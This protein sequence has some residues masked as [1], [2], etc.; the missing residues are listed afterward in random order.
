MKIMTHPSTT[1]TSHQPSLNL[2]PAPV[3][4]WQA[5]AFWL[6]LGFI[7]FGGPAG[8]IAMMHKELVEERRWISE[9]RF[10]HALNYCMLLPGPEAQQLATYIG[11][12][13]HRTWGGIAAGVLFVLPSLLILMGLSWIYI[14]YGSLPLV[15][16]LF[17]GI[18][19]AVTAIVL[20]A[21][22]R[23]G[24]RALKNNWLWGIAGASFVAIF[25][26]NVPFPLIVVVAAMVGYF[27]GRLYPNVFKVGGGHGAAKATY[28]TALI[29]DDTPTPEHAQFK[30]SR[31]FMVLGMGLVLWLLPML[32]LVAWVGWDHIYTQMSWFFTKAA[33]LTFGGAYAVLPYVYQG[34]VDGFAWLSPTQ[35]V[36]GLALGETTPGPLIMVVAFVAFVGAYLKAAAVAATAPQVLFLS[37]C[38]AACLVTWFT[39]LPSFIFILAGG[40]FIEST[41]NDLKFTAPLTAITAAVVGVI[42]NLAL[43]FGY[44]VMW[45]MG[46]KGSFDWIS[47]AIAVAAAIALFQ[48]KRN[49]IHVIVG[50]ALLGLLIKSL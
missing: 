24:S 20:Q 18:K 30:Q 6:K 14:A 46:L 3:T 1:P 43:F 42:A 28:G 22:H 5:F 34:A 11:W 10:L 35:M 13:M 47:A 19:P 38:I 15:A 7:S 12:L 31:L 27:G 4:F 33:L 41:H 23:I 50:C 37:G 40:P 21:A 17:Y 8:Q 16:G 25:A 39:F 49:V 9:K 48:Y 45:P 2:A 32:A 44:H 29:N 36:D 26:L